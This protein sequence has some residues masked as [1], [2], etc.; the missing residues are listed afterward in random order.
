M[1]KENRDDEMIRWTIDQ[2]QSEISFDVRHLMVSH[3]KGEFCQFEAIVL[4]DGKDFSTANITL[5]I[6]SKSINTGD[7]KRDSHLRG[8]DF[9]CTDQHK[10][11]TFRSTSIS[12]AD[13]KGRMDL[14]GD[15]IICGITR[16]VRLDMQMGASSIDS[17]GDETARVTITGKATREDWSLRWTPAM[18]TEG[19]LMGDEIIISC[20]LE[21]ISLAQHDAKR[22]Q[23]P[24]A[25]MR[26]AAL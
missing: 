18:E 21:L 3:V 16:S 13:G 17:W 11:I 20:K 26:V 1:M 22:E 15:L 4:T 7:S 23:D 2:L 5:S 24:V 6:K 12:R 25:L 10:Q 8:P 19:F 14:L 9:L